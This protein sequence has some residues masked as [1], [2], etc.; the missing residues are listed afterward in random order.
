MFDEDVPD[1]AFFDVRVKISKT[2]FE[3]IGAQKIN[4][5]VAKGLELFLESKV[6]EAKSEDVLA[7]IDS[8]MGIARRQISKVG[9]HSCKKC[10]GKNLNFAPD[11]TRIQLEEPDRK[12]KKSK[13]HPYT[14][15]LTFSCNCGH[16]DQIIGDATIYVPKKL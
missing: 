13:S 1:T 15:A 9:D 11:R 4:D 7:T 10:G 14:V 3:A 16:S 12:S 8:M 6:D 2:H 5:A